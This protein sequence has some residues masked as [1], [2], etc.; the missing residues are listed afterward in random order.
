MKRFTVKIQIRPAGAKL[1][2]I[3]ATF[4]AEADAA[5]EIIDACISTF[6]AKLDDQATDPAL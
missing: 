6:E 1:D 2:S 4:Q 3:G 5:S